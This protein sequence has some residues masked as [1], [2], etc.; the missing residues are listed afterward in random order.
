V[1][2][3]CPF[4]DVTFGR[5][6]AREHRGKDEEV[7]QLGIEECFATFDDD[8]AR[9]IH[10]S[11]AAVAAMKGD[12]IE[13]VGDGNDACGE[14][15]AASLQLPGVAGAVPPFMMVE[16]AAR[17]LRIEPVEWREDVGAPLGVGEDGAA[18]RGRELA[19]VVNDVEERFVDLADVVKQGNALDASGVVLIESGGFGEDEC[20]VGDAPDMGAGFHVV[21]VDGVEE[22]LEGG[23]G[24]AF[25]A[26]SSRSLTRCS[27]CGCGHATGDGGDG[28]FGNLHVPVGGKVRS[29]EVRSDGRTV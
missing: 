1:H 3:N 20:V 18:L 27:V 24:E 29:D 4:R 21:C 2:G 15:D 22:G 28:G 25:C 11:P 17:E 16:H 23:G 12:G 14:R 13:R 7:D 6:N 10:R 5:G 8:V 26:L 19:V 9:N